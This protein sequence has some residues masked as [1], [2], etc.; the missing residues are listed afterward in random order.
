MKFRANKHPSAH[1]PKELDPCHTSLM[2]NRFSRKS[3]ASPRLKLLSA[4]WTA[5]AA[6]AVTFVS[7]DST[8]AGVIAPQLLLKIGDITSL[9]Q[10]IQ[11]LPGEAASINDGG[12]IAVLANVSGSGTGQAVIAVDVSATGIITVSN[13][14]FPISSASRNYLA[15]WRLNDGKIGTRDQVS[16]SG[17]ASLIRLWNSGSFVILAS[18]TRNGFDFV[19]TPSF[20][21]DGSY[22]SYVG[23]KGNTG[24]YL[25]KTSVDAIPTPF[26]LTGGG[27]RPMTA[28][29]GRTVLRINNNTQIAVFAS[30]KEPEVVSPSGMTNPGASAGI[31][32]DGR[33]VAFIGDLAGVSVIQVAMDSLGSYQNGVLYTVAQ[34]SKAGSTLPDPFQTWQ[35]SNKDKKIEASE[36][37]GGL[38]SFPG[39]FNRISIKEI[40]KPLGRQLIFTFLGVGV[41]G[42]TG[43]YY[44]RMDRDSGRVYGTARIA[45]TSRDLDADSNYS[46]TP[47]S[48]S[49]FDPLNS[50]GQI[51][52]QASDIS[53]SGVFRVQ[54][55]HFTKYKQHAKIYPVSAI[56]AHPDTAWFN[57]PINPNL[58]TAD[59]ILMTRAGCALTATATIAGIFGKET[60]PLEMR[61]F[62]L[63]RKAIVGNETF[64]TE[65]NLKVGSKT[66]RMG[67][68]GGTLKSIVDELQRGYPLLLAVP[69]SGS[70]GVA[71][72]NVAPKS[73]PPILENLVLANGNLQANDKRH[74][75]LAYG[76][77][78]ALASD[79]PVS[80]S[81]IYISDPGNVR[82][83]KEKYG[84]AYAAGEETV[85][86]TLQDYFKLINSSEKY[87]F[88]AEQWFDNSSFIRKSDKKT[89]QVRSDDR[90]RQISRFVIFEEAPPVISHV[91]VASPV[92]IR[93][94]IGGITY[95]SSVA[96]AQPGDV[97]IAKTWADIVAQFDS[98]TED[99]VGEDEPIDPFPP[100]LLELPT[101]VDD[102]Q[103]VRVEIHAVGDGEYTISLDPGIEG[104]TPTGELHGSVSNGEVVI[105]MIG[106]KSEGTTTSFLS[107]EFLDAMHLHLR[108]PSVVG[109]SY[110][111]E[112][113]TNLKSWNA[114]GGLQTASTDNV[115]WTI[116]RDVIPAGFYRVSVMAP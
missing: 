90:L 79:D 72:K 52:F 24:L 57:Q 11:S 4:V 34:P 74:Y 71:Q 91:R 116:D 30:G 61:D 98:E 40:K 65:F 105:G 19:T 37:E 66:L 63:K 58:K 28:N 53:R 97:V 38:S 23:S 114:V 9:G 110:Q 109:A 73:A 2:E 35:D 99:G 29:D 43:V 16:G 101:G 44:A 10:V 81:D 69:N 64:L 1:I 85:D 12:N 36:I 26:P 95:A 67:Q 59:Q 56:A 45:D 6:T 51:V 60:T 42:Q 3:L 92:E 83:Y 15:P 84:L 7:A 113:S 5:I 88:S 27:F 17:P 68:R 33:A 106:G 20:A 104:I 108:L 70:T 50:Y 75:I 8:R 21:R 82:F 77:N 111:L 46:F 86:V 13:F 31:S 107:I 41:D 80:A 14:T 102:G 49:L 76:L 94:T 115:N 78:P 54:A 25:Q 87:E 18:T 96:V 103:V 55:S 112:F 48:F 100:Y 89:V 22:Y 62:F 93:V 32:D 47:T 39:G